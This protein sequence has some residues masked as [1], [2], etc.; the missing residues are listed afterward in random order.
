MYWFD[1][2][3]SVALFSSLFVSLQSLSVLS[4]LLEQD[5]MLVLR[6]DPDR[7]LVC[8]E[9]KTEAQNEIRL[10]LEVQKVQICLGTKRLVK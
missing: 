10:S 6:D 2:S 9:K 1:L 7:V 5:I 4:C 8:K 3:I